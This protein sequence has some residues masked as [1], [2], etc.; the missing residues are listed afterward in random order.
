[1][2]AGPDAEL[3]EAGGGAVG[4]RVELRVGDPLVHELQR[5]KRRR[6]AR[7]DCLEDA[8]ARAPMSSGASQR[9]PAG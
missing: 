7:A 6:S 2:H 8:L 3:L 4:E 9:T 1:M 5:R